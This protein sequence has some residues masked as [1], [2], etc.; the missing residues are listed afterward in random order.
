MS[1]VGWVEAKDCLD[2]VLHYSGEQGGSGNDF[3]DRGSHLRDKIKRWSALGLLL[4]SGLGTGEYVPW[5]L[6]RC[7]FGGCVSWWFF[8]D[9]AFFVG[10]SCRMGW[11]VNGKLFVLLS[12]LGPSTLVAPAVSGL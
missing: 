6:V 11:F 2:L 12:V 3:I 9:S 4:A 7:N 10:F 5:W 1:L 8:Q